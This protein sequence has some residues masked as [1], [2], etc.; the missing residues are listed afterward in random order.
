M[1]KYGK[2]RATLQKLERL[3]WNS[4]YEILMIRIWDRQFHTCRQHNYNSN[5]SSCYYKAHYIKDNF[6]VLGATSDVFK[7]HFKQF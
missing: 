6:C 3:R 2:G 4:V 1:T 5:K 7:V